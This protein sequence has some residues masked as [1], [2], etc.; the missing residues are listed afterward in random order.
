MG[1]ILFGR[2]VRRT[3][4]AERPRTGCVD[5]GGLRPAGAARRLLG[6]RTQEPPLRPPH[7]VHHRQPERLYRLPCCPDAHALSPCLLDLLWGPGGWRPLDDSLL[8]FAARVER[9]GLFCRRSCRRAVP[10]GGTGCLLGARASRPQAERRSAAGHGDGGGRPALPGGMDSLLRGNDEGGRPARVSRLR[11]ALGAVGSVRSG[12][13]ALPRDLLRGTGPGAYRR[14]RVRKGG[15]TRV[16]EELQGE[17]RPAALRGVS[18][19][20]RERDVCPVGAAAPCRHQGCGA[21]CGGA[22]Q[23]AEAGAKLKREID[24]KRVFM[25]PDAS[26]SRVPC[27]PL[28]TCGVPCDPMSLLGAI[29]GSPGCRR[30]VRGL[31]TRAGSGGKRSRPL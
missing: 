30:R 25:L 20:V 21:A 13:Q 19:E 18:G 12:R 15:G 7:Q 14:A 24:F 23:K 11:R 4:T 17:R 27:V 31:V 16:L 28:R 5:G 29:R 3:T 2:M 8:G 26:D 10:A 1:G 9:P 22:R 6:Q